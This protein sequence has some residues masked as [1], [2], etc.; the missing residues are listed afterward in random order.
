M[1]SIL[2]FLIT[3]FAINSI[4]LFSQ[5]HSV[6]REWNETLLFSIKNDFARPTVHARNL[7]HF[8]AAMYDAWAIFDETAKTVFI[9]QTVGGFNIPYQTTSYIDSKEI[10]LHN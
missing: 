1:R 7:F 2:L 10:A 4:A 8:S 6:S 5:S 3:F 9:G